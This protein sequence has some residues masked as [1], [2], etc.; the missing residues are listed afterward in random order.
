M[1]AL[2]FLAAVFNWAL[3]ARRDNRAEGFASEIGFWIML[4]GILGARVAY[5]IANLDFYIQDPL[6]I[7]R[8][9]QGGLIFYGGLIGG[10]V[11]ALG[12]ARKYKEPPLSM[13]DFIITGVPL[14]HFFGRIGCFLN[15]CCYGSPSAP[16]PGIKFPPGSMPFERYNGAAVH[17]TQIYEALLNLVIYIFLFRYYRK[18]PKP[19]KV[20]ALYLL[21]YPPGRFLIEFLRGDPRLRV[22]G[23]SIAQ[24]LSLGLLIIGYF[25][26]RK[27]TF[28]RCDEQ[29]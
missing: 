20:L 17:P 25:L 9:D 24:L 3:L 2:G 10:V 5:I 1:F 15:G 29:M 12:L 16:L 19:G 7:I 28:R 13:G 11:A 8:I 18:S 23:L 21:T 22:M 4:G 14:G 26:W 6:A 27:L